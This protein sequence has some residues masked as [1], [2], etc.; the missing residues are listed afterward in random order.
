M[1][2]TPLYYRLAMSLLKPLYQLKLASKTTLPNEKQQRFGQV[3]P[4]IH[5]RQ[6]MIWCHAVSLGETNTAEPILR[7]LLSQGYA[8]WVTN[9]THTGYNRVEQLFAP[10]IAAS[11]VYHSFVP[12]DSKAVIDKFLAHVQ[13]VA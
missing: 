7:D 3:F 11:K 8:L 13:P 9:T 2:A 10:E 4:K 5:T 1:Q 6:P 12:V